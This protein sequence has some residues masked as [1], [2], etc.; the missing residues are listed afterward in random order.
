MRNGVR[1]WLQTHLR[2]TF[3][4]SPLGHERLHWEPTLYFYSV[5]DLRVQSIWVRVL[6]IE[7]GFAFVQ[8]GLQLILI[9]SKFYFLN[10]CLQLL[11]FKGHSLLSKG[12]VLY[13]DVLIWIFLEL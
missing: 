9:L 4:K 7:I 10:Q 11:L 8:I 1:Q 2:D 5:S 6:L 3:L 12:G 13:Y